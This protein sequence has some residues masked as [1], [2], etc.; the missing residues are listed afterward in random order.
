MKLPFK[1]KTDREGFSDRRAHAYED[2]PVHTYEHGEDSCCHGFCSCAYGGEISKKALLILAARLLAAVILLILSAIPAIG[3]SSLL[4]EYIFSTAAFLIAGYN[5]LWNAVKSI[6]KKRFFDKNVLISIAG[7]GALIIR[8]CPEGVLLIILSQIG[9]F[10]QEYTVKKSRKSIA[11]RW[12]IQADTVQLIIGNEIIT[13]P[14]EDVNTGDIF[15]VYPGGRIP[16][17]GEILVGTSEVDTSALT[18]APAPRSV[19]PGDTVLSGCVNI[20]NVLTVKATAVLSEST[21]SRILRLAENAEKNRGSAEKFMVRFAAIYTPA[22]FAFAFVIAVFVPL[23]F[24]LPFM[25]WIHRALVLLVIASPCALVISVPLTYFAGIGGA[26]RQGIIVKGAEGI[27]SLAQVT[28]VVFDKTGTLTTGNFQI[29]AIDPIGISEEELLLLAAYAESMSAHPIAKAIVKAAGVK[30]DSSRITASHEERGKGI[31]IQL[32]KKI[33]VS[34]GNAAFM[35]ELQTDIELA[36]NDNTKV[37]VALERHCVGSI[38]VSDTIRK[39]AANAVY[40]LNNIGI[41][42]VVMIT[43][44]RTAA[45]EETARRLG[46]HEVYAQCLTEEKADKL[47]NLR[48]MQL[49]GE[50]L[51]YIGSGINDVSIMALGD[52]GIAMGGLGSDAAVETADVLILTDEPSKVSAALV[53]SRDTKKIILQNIGFALAVKALILL[54]ALCGVASMWL[55]VLVD[56]VIAL[57]TVFHAMRAFDPETYNGD[58]LLSKFKKA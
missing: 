4:M 45:A 38:T 24:T 39:D 1:K 9:E 44:D 58:K 37:Y 25:E 42:R 10:F 27:D 51:A 52:V 15:I 19:V 53:S 49:S 6:T 7:I 33:V 17:D 55:A 22:V 3:G 14:A 54:L 11:A 48:D 8:E 20:A 32:D 2:S 23:I 5:I 16:L 21:F 50:K 40:A 13:V 30:I 18:G 41:D 28:S 47:K 26:S 12:D 36:A 56:A 35:N 29:T 43:E 34:A 57:L 31:V 46:I